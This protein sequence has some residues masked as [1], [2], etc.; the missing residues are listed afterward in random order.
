MLAR[1]AALVRPEIETVHSPHLYKSTR[2][3][4]CGRQSIFRIKISSKKQ[5]KDMRHIVNR[6]DAH[7]LIFDDLQQALAYVGSLLQ[8]N[9]QETLQEGGGDDITARGIGGHHHTPGL[10]T[11]V[12]DTLFARFSTASQLNGDEPRSY[13]RKGE[14]RV[15]ARTLVTGFIH[16]LRRRGYEVHAVSARPRSGRDHLISEL[17]TCPEVGTPASVHVYPLEFPDDM[18]SEL[19]HES[20]WTFK[21][22]QRQVCRRFMCCH[23]EIG[24][25]C[26]DCMSQERMREINASLER[27]IDDDAPHTVVSITP[28]R[29]GLRV[30]IKL[31][32]FLDDEYAAEDDSD[33]EPEE[34]GET[35]D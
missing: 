5:Q 33:Y 29:H 16:S 31:P 15:I 28:A 8:R 22:A 26:W 9:A 23:I 10:L 25:R 4:K 19:F 1:F 17:R 27:D 12:D 3:R 20:L 21:E 2:S 13:R 35:T 34:N 11:D 18:T 32:P 7:V 24:D 6:K 14:H 30:G